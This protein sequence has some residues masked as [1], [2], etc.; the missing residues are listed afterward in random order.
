MR[1]KGEMQSSIEQE[2]LWVVMNDERQR[3]KDRVRM[4][5][6]DLERERE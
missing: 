3:E 6:E 5:M 2:R 4:R 1:I